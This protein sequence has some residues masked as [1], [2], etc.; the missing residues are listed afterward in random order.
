ME[1]MQAFSFEIMQCGSVAALQAFPGSN[2]V[3]GLFE[4]IEWPILFSSNTLLISK[5]LNDCETNM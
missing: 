3:L 4:C 2:S 5:V 1:C